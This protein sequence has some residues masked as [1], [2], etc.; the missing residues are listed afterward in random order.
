VAQSVRNRFSG[1]AAPRSPLSANSTCRRSGAEPRPQASSAFKETRPEPA[2]G[3]WVQNGY[4]ASQEDQEWLT[5]QGQ[6]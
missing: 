3:F 1:L 6:D 4:L 5:G 2:F